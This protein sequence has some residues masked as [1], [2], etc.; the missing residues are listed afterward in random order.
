MGENACTQARPGVEADTRTAAK[1]LVPE[2]V[3]A[4]CIV[5]KRV[6]KLDG[7]ASHT[8]RSVASRGLQANNVAVKVSAGNRKREI[9]AN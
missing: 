3:K 7:G 6:S 1:L 9:L 4:S 5:T 8:D 2:G